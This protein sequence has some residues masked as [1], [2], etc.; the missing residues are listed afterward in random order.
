MTPKTVDS[1]EIQCWQESMGTSVHCFDNSLK[2]RKHSH[3]FHKTS[4]KFAPEEN[5]QSQPRCAR[6]C[7]ST[8]LSSSRIT[9]TTCRPRPSTNSSPC[10]L[11]KCAPGTKA[12]DV[13]KVHHRDLHGHIGCLLLRAQRKAR[14]RERAHHVNISLTVG[15]HRRQ[16]PLAGVSP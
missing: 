10:A 11:G 13:L 4:Q 2:R 12:L 9:F 5:S 7:W 14:E 15:V 8:Y 16:T 1:D 3:S 6:K